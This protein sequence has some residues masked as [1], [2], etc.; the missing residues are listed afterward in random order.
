MSPQLRNRNLDIAYFDRLR[1]GRS[2][3][4]NRRNAIADLDH[5][6]HYGY[7]LPAPFL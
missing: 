4:V 2:G 1:Q 5:A 6:N 7:A 3:I